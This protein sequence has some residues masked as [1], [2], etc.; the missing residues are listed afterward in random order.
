MTKLIVAFRNFANSPRDNIS[1]WNYV[2]NS[3]I[4]NMTDHRQRGRRRN[5]RIQHHRQPL[6]P[7]QSPSEWAPATPFSRAEAETRIWPFTPIQRPHYSHG[8]IPLILHVFSWCGACLRVHWDSC[9]LYTR[10]HTHTHTH[11]HTVDQFPHNRIHYY[12]VQW[13]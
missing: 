13:V 6:G 7:N 3:S 11:T 10:A 1:F 5:F 2:R 12:A 9:H 4:I 8:L